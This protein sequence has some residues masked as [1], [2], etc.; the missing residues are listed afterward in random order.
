M[1]QAATLYARPSGPAPHTRPTRR[2]RFDPTNVNGRWTRV[3]R[4][5]CLTPISVTDINRSVRRY[6]PDRTARGE[7]A[8][9]WRAV[10]N[11]VRLGLLLHDADRRYVATGAGLRALA[12]VPRAA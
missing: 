7:K 10:S 11:L 5:C 1:T 8:R 3:L 6:G 4:A 2:W 12:E 9:T